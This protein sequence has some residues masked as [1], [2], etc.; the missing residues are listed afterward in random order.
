MTGY[1]CDRAI[2]AIREILYHPVNDDGH[3]IAEI[4]GVLGCIQVHAPAVRKT[5][6][7]CSKCN[8]VGPQK[9]CG[10]CGREI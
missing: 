8:E 5:P 6:K 10:I 3:L 9:Y 2:V 4:K 1:T 7:P